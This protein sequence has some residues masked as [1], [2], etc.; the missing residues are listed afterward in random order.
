MLGTSDP[1]LPRFIHKFT[2]NVRFGDLRS[3]EEPVWGPLMDVWET[4]ATILGNVGRF[5][6]SFVMA[7]FVLANFCSVVV[8]VGQFLQ[9]C[10]KF[11]SKKQAKH[12]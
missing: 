11:V 5:W 10:F 6:Q 12:S 1:F 4:T 3:F 7:L 2:R 8:P 9:S